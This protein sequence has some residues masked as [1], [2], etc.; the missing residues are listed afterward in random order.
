MGKEYGPGH[1][2]ITVTENTLMIIYETSLS[3]VITKESW[4]N[5]GIA[6]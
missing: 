1:S 2:E 5:Y 4:S 6:S 3:H